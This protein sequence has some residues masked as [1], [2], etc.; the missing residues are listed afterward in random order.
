[1][2]TQVKDFCPHHWRIATPNGT[3][4]RGVCLRCGAERDFLN[5]GDKPT[6]TP[7]RAEQRQIAR[8]RRELATAYVEDE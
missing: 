7:S 5:W 4:S 2:T 1:M 3:T 6:R 8:A